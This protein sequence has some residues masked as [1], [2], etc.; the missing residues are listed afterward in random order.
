MDLWVVVVLEE[1]RRVV[2]GSEAMEVTLGCP[3]P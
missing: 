3:S 2:M 1:I